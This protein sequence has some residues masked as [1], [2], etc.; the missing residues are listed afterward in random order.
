MMK[1]VVAMSGG[2]DSAVTAA[3]MRR[4][5]HDVIG[6]TL[7]LADLSALGLGASR[8]CSASDVASAREVARLLGIPHYV[9]DF[10]ATFRAEVLEPFVASY[11]A[12]E[13]PLPC[14]R[15]NSRLKFGE[16]L[17]VAD[18]FG[19]EMLAS[20][21]YAR[22]EA[23]SSGVP[24]LRR[25][26]DRDKDQSYFLFELAQRQLA[27]VVF[28]LG[29]MHKTEVRRL[30]A[31]MGLPN[32][33]RPDSQ[34]VCFVP[35]GASYVGVLEKLASG[36]LPGVGEIVDAGGA[37]LGTHLGFHR[38]TIGQRRGIGVP[39]RS[40]LYVIGV[41]AERNRVIV[42]AAGDTLRTRLW[43]RD[44]NWLD[45]K[46]PAQARAL[47]QIRSRHDPASAEIELSG[48]E[49]AEVRFAAPVS[50][51]APGQAAVFYDGDR[52]LGGG[53]IVKTE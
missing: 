11:L 31:E 29:G 2:V 22:V 51:P 21:H 23:G 32:A 10:E 44:V 34:E 1:I 19:A 18:Q 42:G 37:A 4:A 15:C 24:V 36:R 20:G 26:S 14:A 49:C 12:G 3:L 25:G 27:R 53:W 35:E 17:G 33:D 7:Q 9:L 5:G 41:D 39:S 46:R 50:S 13:T 28:P 8:C 38:Y 6:V 45:G 16:L 48:G 43:L 30:A 52:L 47:V 40:R